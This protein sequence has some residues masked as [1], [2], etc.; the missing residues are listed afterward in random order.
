MENEDPQTCVLRLIQEATKKVTTMKTTETLAQRLERER[1]EL[2]I[3]WNR[4]CLSELLAEPQIVASLLASLV[5]PSTETEVVAIKAPIS[6]T[7]PMHPKLHQQGVVDP[8]G[9]CTR[10]PGSNYKAKHFIEGFT[11]TWLTN[12]RQAASQTNGSTTKLKVQQAVPSSPRAGSPM[13]KWE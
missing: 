3:Q 4:Y 5:V 8:H 13:P 2:I 12:N 11:K 7:Q 6:P 1:N 9:G 10:S